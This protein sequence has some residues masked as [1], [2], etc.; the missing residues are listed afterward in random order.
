M[1]TCYYAWLLV[2]LERLF[3][4]KYETLLALQ[5]GGMYLMTLDTGFSDVTA[6]YLFLSRDAKFYC[7]K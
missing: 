7:Y 6:P 2:Y 5:H 4:F 1:L 3:C